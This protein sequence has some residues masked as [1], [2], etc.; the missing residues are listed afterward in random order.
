VLRLALRNLFQNKVRFA[1]SVGGVAL[2]LTLML[3]LDAIVTGAEQRLT[4]YIDHAGADVWVSQAGVRQL[5]MTS[6]S[7]PAAAVD[8]VRAVPGV[9]SATPILYMTNMVVA[10]DSR[11]LAYVIGVP[12]K[13]PVGGAWHVAK[14][15]SVPGPGEA[16]IDRS[17]ADKAHI[18]LGSTVTILGKPLRVTGLS[19]GTVSLTNSV[20][21]VSFQDF[22]A[23]R[24]GGDTGSFV[25]V[26]TTPGERAATLAARIAPA[27]PGVTVQTRQQVAAQER[28]LAKTMTTDLITIMNLVGFL[29]GLAVMAL[30]VYLATFARRAEYGVLR[31]LGARAGHLYRVVLAQAFGSVAVGFAVGL[32]VTL[33]LAALVPRLAATSRWRCAVA[34][35]SA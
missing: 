34:R 24:G 33:L 9:A 11:S 2:A 17:V 28:R 10:G 35:C 27:V 22:A 12:A 15:V 31:A 14:G 25:L 19:E 30:T 3:A 1:V 8:Q 7:L 29:I 20:A 21:L 32:A 6:S 13:S 26:T 16:V 23:V 18:G 4:A 5:H